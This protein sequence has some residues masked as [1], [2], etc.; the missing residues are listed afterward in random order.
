M[1]LASLLPCTAQILDINFYGV[2]PSYM[3][4]TKR[5]LVCP[6]FYSSLAGMLISSN[7]PS[8]LRWSDPSFDIGFLPV[9]GLPVEPL[10]MSKT[11]VVIVDI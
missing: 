6:Y 8:I 3:W 11:F 4:Y 5:L 2:L 7:P 10:P 9:V 1:D